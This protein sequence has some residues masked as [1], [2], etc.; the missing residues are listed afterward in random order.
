MSRIALF[1]LNSLLFP[2][3][4]IDLQI[5][6]QRYLSM[7]SECLKAEKGFG[8]VLIREGQE[9]GEVPQ[10]FPVGVY[11]HIEDWNSL[12]NGLLGIKVRGG[13]KFRILECFSEHDRLVADIEYLPDEPPVEICE[14]HE[15]LRDLLAQLLAHPAVQRLGFPEPQDA[16]QLGWQLTQL[17]P[18][19]RPDKVALLEVKDPWLR[20]DQ[21]VERVERLAAGEDPDASGRI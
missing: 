17:L 4:T 15:G 3:A 2:E 16:R 6:E 9:A 1:P 10:I 7:I 19:S 5:F 8:V 21:I 14:H 12:D 20:L 18:L 11:G 13:A